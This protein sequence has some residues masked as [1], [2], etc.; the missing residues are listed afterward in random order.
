MEIPAK[1]YNEKFESFLKI[2]ESDDRFDNV[3]KNFL[4]SI[5]SALYVNA[6]TVTVSGY[7]N[8]E[9]LSYELIADTHKYTVFAF[10]KEFNRNRYNAM[11]K[12]L[13]QTGIHV[14]DK[15]HPNGDAEEIS[16]RGVVYPCSLTCAV[17]DTNKYVAYFNLLSS[18]PERVWSPEEIQLASRLTYIL[19]GM[20][21]TRR[22]AEHAESTTRTLTDVM[23]NMNSYVLAVAQDSGEI[24]FASKSF[25]QY[26]GK[27]VG[28]KESDVFSKTWCE[29][30]AHKEGMLFGG[31]YYSEI[32]N[33]WF[34]VSEKLI[35]WHDGR[36]IR[37]CTLNDISEKINYERVIEKQ[38][39]YDNLTGLPNRLSLDKSIQGIIESDE[40]S[41][42]MLIDLDNFKNINDSYG[43][44]NGDR[45]LKEIGKFFEDFA[46]KNKKLSIFR[47]GSD[48]FVVLLRDQD[49][50]E[51][52]EICKIIHDKFNTEWQIANS[53]CY[54]TCS[55]GVAKFPKLDDTVNTVLKRIDLAIS[56]AKKQGK[57][58]TINY[59][60]TI[61][62]ILSRQIDLERLMHRDI[63]NGFAHFTAYYQPIFS[64]SEKKL[65]G[66]E[67]LM[68][69]NPP[70]FGQVSPAEFIPMAERLGYI[71]LL[72]E[73]IIRIAGRQCKKWADAGLDLRM[74]INLSVGQ[75]I[76]PDFLDKIDTLF[77]ETGAPPDK[78]CFEVTESLAIHDMEKMKEL[79]KHIT[80]KGVKI[81]LDDFGTGYSSLNC[82]K[83]MPLNTIKI[84]KS[85]IDDIA[86]NPDT[87]VFVKMI[88][89][90]SH[91]LHIAVC[92]EG[93]EEQVQFDI[94]RDLE[95]DVIQGYYF[96]RPMPSDKFEEKFLSEK[97]QSVK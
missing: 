26:L 32:M 89:N 28:K 25:E 88:V 74:N 2:L 94:L 36:T 14:A 1:T 64:S 59:N 46:R 80:D 71:N 91:D 67:A 97:L 63:T 96:G 21:H 54:C 19:S 81:A 56:Y 93:V 68:R 52:D 84:D 48:E 90:L 83:E 11:K 53:T 51:I 31:D 85:F 33:K 23:D 27:L 79:L 50:A 45:L 70:E 87:A 41:T 66:C 47:F 7:E 72:G 42:V 73:N 22:A 9:P 30:P 13:M 49:Q 17:K 6:A 15:A 57:N 44:N 18:D 86:K 35:K 92:A 38:V 20:L 4:E 95:T 29:L 39:F 40:N 10:D 37:L 60:E 77:D 16:L 55:M 12:A 62:R 34:N 5:C 43:H 61:G 82:I 24:V 8:S 69:W 65:V 3:C 58:C 76:E 75:I 78:I